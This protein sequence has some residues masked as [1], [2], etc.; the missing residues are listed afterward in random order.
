MM[1]PIYISLVIEGDL[2]RE[3][4]CTLMEHTS[5]NVGKSYVQDGKHRLWE[6]VPRYN[7]AVSNVPHLFY[8]V[9]ADLD[10]EECPP[11]L[12]QEKLP[13]GRH[14]NLLIRI[15]VREVESWLLADRKNFARFLN[16]SVKNMPRNPD[17]EDDPKR[18]LIEL[19]KRSRR[20]IVREEIVPPESSTRKVGPNYSG[21]LSHFVRNYW[22]IETARKY[23]PSLDRAID[24]LKAFSHR[25]RH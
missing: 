16:I 3:V 10:D 5:L 14:P 21:Q 9:L 17:Q 18:K 12:I 1:T 24:A 11:K 19:A 6:N 15:A 22:D 8:I 20:R 13:E 25:L 4:L 23:S 2:D 7:I